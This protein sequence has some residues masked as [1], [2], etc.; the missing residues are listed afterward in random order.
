MGTRVS[1]M[2]RARLL[3]LLAALAIPAVAHGQQES[4]IAAGLT[5]IAHGDQ[6]V[7]ILTGI[8]TLPEGGQ[9]VDRVNGMT[10][11]AETLRYLAGEFV[12]GSGVEVKGG[13]G[14][15]RADSVR[16]DLV[17]GVVEAV[18]SVRFQRDQIGLSASAL[19]YDAKGQV[20][21]FDGP[22]TSEG[23]EFEA[24]TMLLD[25]QS[26]S[27]VLVG[28]YRYQDER[29]ELS[30]ERG[31]ALL[32]LRPSEGED[33]ELLASSRVDPELLERLGPYLP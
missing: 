11:T 2:V 8:T 28:P 30:S 24:A 14:Q 21:R 7:D 15:A 4:P 3:P 10:L 23:I 1:G 6:E 17:E 25:V 31:G 13:F 16:V 12:E 26:G 20:L 18:G 33:G 22:V 29:L 27:V 19:H 9:V 5:V 32:S